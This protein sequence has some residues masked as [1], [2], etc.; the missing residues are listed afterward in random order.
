MIRADGEPRRF[1]AAA[2]SRHRQLGKQQHVDTGHACDVDHQQMLLQV[3]VE[4]E[5][6]RLDLRGSDVQHGS[7]GHIKRGGRPEASRGTFGT[8]EPGSIG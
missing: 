1:A 2:V 4:V 3:R 5:R 8:F 6:Y 7:G